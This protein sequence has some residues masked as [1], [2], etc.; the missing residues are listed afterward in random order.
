M[1]NKH[2][3]NKIYR[4]SQHLHCCIPGIFPR[5]DDN[6]LFNLSQSKKINKKFSTLEFVFKQES[7]HH[8]IS[9]EPYLYLISLM[10]PVYSL[11]SFDS[12]NNKNLPYLFYL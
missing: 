1:F 7:N 9:S 11:T 4:L 8:Q 2:S 6:F 10:F 3:K 5:S 12:G